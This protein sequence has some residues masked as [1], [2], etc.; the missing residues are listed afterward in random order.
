[1]RPGSQIVKNVKSAERYGRGKKKTA[2][3]GGELQSRSVER[4]RL[5]KT[6][7]PMEGFLWEQLEGAAG[8]R[9]VFI[10]RKGC[11]DDE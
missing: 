6:P 9:P 8:L 7:Q 10:K 2:D 11:H 3:V 4:E 1:L 5:F